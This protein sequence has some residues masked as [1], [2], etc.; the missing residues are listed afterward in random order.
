MK[1]LAL[2]ITLVFIALQIHA[3]V[4]PEKEE[5]KPLKRRKNSVYFEGFG[6]SLTYSINYERIFS[7][8][9]N[10][11][12]ALRTGFSYTKDVRSIPLEIDLILGKKNCFESGIGLTF[13]TFGEGN[14]LLL[15]AGYRYRDPSGLLIRLAPMLMVIPG[16]YVGPYGGVSMGYSF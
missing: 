3:Q 8:E 2:V 7:W 14:T 6:N 1:K 10:R 11:A 13:S 5:V 9:V 4:N 12:V 15:R 16:Y